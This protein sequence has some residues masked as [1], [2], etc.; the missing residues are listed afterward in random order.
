MCLDL[1]SNDASISN[2]DSNITANLSLPKLLTN[3]GYI[4][5]KNKR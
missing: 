2:F 3:S 5:I 1:G 4:K